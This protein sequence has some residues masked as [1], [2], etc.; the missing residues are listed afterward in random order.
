MRQYQRASGE[1]WKDPSDDYPKD[2]SHDQWQY[3]WSDAR[4]GGETHGPY[5]VITMKSWVD[6]GYFG[7][8]V[9]Y[10]KIGADS[11]S[12]DPEFI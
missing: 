7:E 4:D 10:Q 5:D 6:A 2:T 12:R 8:G 1:E 9:E 3:R 11:W